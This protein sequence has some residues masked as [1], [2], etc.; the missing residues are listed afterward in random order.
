MNKTETLQKRTP[1][2]GTSETIPKCGMKEDNAG[3]AG[4]DDV[5]HWPTNQSCAIL[6]HKLS[7]PSQHNANFGQSAEGLY[8]NG[9]KRLRGGKKI[10]KKITCWHPAPPLPEP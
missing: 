1:L 3:K 2:T 4:Q 7:K 9:P 8:P 10:E 6:L 5:I